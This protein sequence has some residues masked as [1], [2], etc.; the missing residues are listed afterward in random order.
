MQEIDFKKNTS[1]GVEVLHSPSKEEPFAIIR[2]ESG[3]AS[4]PLSE[5]DENN[6]FSLASK[7]FPSLLE[8]KASTAGRKE[9]EHGL[10]HRLDTATE[11]LLLIASSQDFFDK[12]I[13]E[14]KK[15][16]FVKTY[17]AE[18]DF[19]K[20]NAG[21]LG[22]FPENDFSFEIFRNDYK[23]GRE[24][25]LQ[26]YFRNYGEKSRLVRPV[27][28]S[29]GKAAVKKSSGKLYSTKIKLLSLEEPMNEKSGKALVE[30][31]ISEG[32]RH[33]VR[34]HLAWIGL[35]V[36]GDE[37]YNSSYSE[38]KKLKFFATGLE[39]LGLSFSV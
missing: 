21:K 34:C 18:C 38:G 16:G 13:E 4:A 9:C 39:F 6:A 15:G 10:L 29:S 37:L 28:E 33:Q 25:S 17:R 1:S 5:S 20:E 22:G 12:M 11:G 3:L 23:E 26:S 32:F 31:K 24:I 27:T 2:K 7:L 14:Q 36:I 19:V 35:P 30:C 8:V